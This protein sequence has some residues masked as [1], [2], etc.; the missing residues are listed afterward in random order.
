MT[1]DEK[2]S[3]VQADLRRYLVECPSRFNF[4]CNKAARRD[5]RRA[6]FAAASLD[7]KYLDQ[8]FP[9]LRP[10]T[11]LDSKTASSSV[12]EKE[13]KMDEDPDP[14]KDIDYV[15]ASNRQNN[16]FIDPSHPE[17]PC[18]RKFRKGEPLYRCLY[19]FWWRRIV[20]QTTNY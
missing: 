14:S 4:R 8:F 1:D 7:G 12:D 6:L 9:N 17:R 10:T 19:V 16:A 18:V 5:L 11:V 2:Q 15:M 3:K 13:E 20:L